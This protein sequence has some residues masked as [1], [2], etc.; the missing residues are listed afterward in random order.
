MQVDF[1]CT[2]CG[3]STRVSLDLGCPATHDDPKVFPTVLP[4]ACPECGVEIDA[5]VLAERAQSDNEAR[6]QEDADARR[7]AQKE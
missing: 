1:D 7:R 4:D 5:D 2:C 3:C 6:E